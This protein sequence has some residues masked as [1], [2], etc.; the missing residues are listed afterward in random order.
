MRRGDWVILDELNLAPSE[1]LEALNRLLD[2]NRQLYLP[3]INQVIK[4][5]PNFRLFATQNPCGAYGGRKPLSRAFRNRFVE[6]H[7]DDIPSAEMTTILEKRCSC[8]PSHAKALVA[9]MDALRQRRSKSGVF[10]GKDGL[11]TPRDLLRWA[12]RRA[13]SKVRLAQDGYMLLAER[14]RTPDEKEI[15]KDE[16]EKQLKL[17]ID[18]DELY[19]SHQS[20]AWKELNSFT[21]G[22]STSAH[23]SKLVSAIAPTKS[24]LRLMNLIL[25]C[26]RQRE[27]VLLVGGKR[28]YYGIVSW[29]LFVAVKI[30]HI[31]FCSASE[32][33]GNGKT[34]VV[35]LLSILLKSKL[36]IVNCHATTETSDLIGG[37]RPVRG[38][39]AI[40]QQ[41][42]EKVK[43]LLVKWPDRDALKTLSIPE[44][45]YYD[46]S[47]K[48][49]SDGP[50]EPADEMMEPLFDLPETAPSDM[51]KLVRLLRDSAAEQLSDV[52]TESPRKK[53]KLEESQRVDRSDVLAPEIAEIEELFRRH[54]SLFEW[55]DGPVA[56]AMKDGD[57]LLLDE[58]SLAEDAVLERLNSV[59]EPSRTLVLAE[60]GEDESTDNETDSRVIEADD[61]FRIFATMNPGGDFG[62]RELSPALRS[63][64]TEIWVPPVDDKSDIELVLGRSL[65]V[66]DNDVR[67]CKILEKML[68]YVEWFNNSVC[69]DPSSPYPGL[70]LSLRD[71]L[72]WTR[73]VTKAR[74]ANHDLNVWDAYCHGAALM[75]LDGLG[76]GTGLSLEETS[77]MSARARD[78]LANQ[79]DRPDQVTAFAKSTG[80]LRFTSAQGLFGLHPFWVQTGQHGIGESSFNFE[81]P[82]TAENVYRVLRAM[83][84]SKPILLEGKIGGDLFFGCVS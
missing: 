11:I 41:M 45:L 82:R 72:A 8:P 19:F 63:R 4:P 25:R 51:I 28:I 66:A 13:S 9:I 75:H 26:I 81:A 65:A 73:F 14:L 80:N 35:D 27:P 58:L 3:E 20:A 50:A 12:E 44:Y 77:S 56:A 60:K 39:N 38:R 10:M 17:K 7:I 64:F 48:D 6:L 61:G 57:M 49:M 67:S 1:V 32:D 53:P 31:F 36:R 74:E 62:K 22:L 37:L 69:K 21:E 42:R 47:T 78:F 46:N 76:L 34:T 55:A 2:D 33:T 71:V 5:H 59:L 84:L 79:V 15:V 68:D 29:L 83:Q 52:A 16:I 70:I 54:S 23:E 30:A 18:V 24:M 43:E 40:V